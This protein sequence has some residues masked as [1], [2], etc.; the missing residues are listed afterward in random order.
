MRS[1]GGYHYYFIASTGKLE[2]REEVS[3]DPKSLFR[4]WLFSP[5]E[6]SQQV[7]ARNQDWRITVSECTPMSNVAPPN[8]FQRT[9]EGLGLKRRLKKLLWPKNR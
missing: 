7:L 1:I 4:D 2:H 6:L 9:L 8:P 5:T 3:G